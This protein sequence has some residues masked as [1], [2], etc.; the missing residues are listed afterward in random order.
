[1]AQTKPSK[2]QDVYQILEIVHKRWHSQSAM[3]K[4]T[5]IDLS[6]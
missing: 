4:D 5:C 3:F 1:M 6:F 2:V